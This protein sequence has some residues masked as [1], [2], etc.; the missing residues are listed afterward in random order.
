MSIYRGISLV[1]CKG[2]S[3]TNFDKNNAFFRI[4]GGNISYIPMSVVIMTGMGVLFAIIYSKGILGRHA[5]AIGSNLEAAR[6]TGVKIT[7]VRLAVLT[8]MGFIV[9]V[10]AL[11][12]FA[13]LESADPSV[14]QG[15]ELLTIA[16]AIIGGTALRGGSG[17]VVGALLG[18]IIIGVIQNGLLLMGFTMY[19]STIVTGVIIIVAVAIN[20]LVTGKQQRVG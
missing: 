11:V 8:L 15:Y 16:A 4:I 1:L 12:G 5:C 6:V 2:R 9:A 13:F 7:R 10:S 18:A 17:S 14:G 3:I 20:S 19:W